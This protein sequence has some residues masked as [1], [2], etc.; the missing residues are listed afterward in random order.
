MNFHIKDYLVEDDGKSKPR[1]PASAP[2]S[3]HPTT[4]A[5]PVSH[6][7]A[8]PPVA[9]ASTDSAT[10]STDTAYQKLLDHTD[11]T[12]TPIYQ[13]LQKYLAPLADVIP[14][15]RVRFKAAVKQASAQTG[16]AP[17]SVASTFDQLNTALADASKSF[18]ES[19]EHAIAEGVTAKNNQADTL[20][21]Q[22]QSLQQQ[23]T[24]LKEDAYNTQVK[25]DAAK[26]RF[27]TALQTRQQEL[28]QEAAK[29][30]NLLA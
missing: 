17:E 20:T 2:S 23:I 1:Q 24:Q 16:F 8:Y 12:Q 26:H 19:A 15:E 4:A 3:Q 11:F 6:P 29:Y 27:D 30:A 5:A 18:G 9:V 22:V 10:S 28:A 21:A 25:I 7:T 13:T 14:D